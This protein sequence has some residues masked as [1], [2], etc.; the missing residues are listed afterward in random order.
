MLRFSTDASLRRFQITGYA[1]VFVVVGILGTWSLTTHLNGAVIA[2]ATIIAE[3]N[4]KR[5]QSKDGG[6]VRKIMVR[7]GE[8]RKSVV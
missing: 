6:I 1:S 2:P 8:D 3:T 4:S 7:D 5:V